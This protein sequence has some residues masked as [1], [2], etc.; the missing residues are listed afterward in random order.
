MDKAKRLLGLAIMVES[1]DIY[2]QL[3]D[4]GVELDHHE[5]DLYAKVTP[6]S[7]A[8]IKN[9]RMKDNVTVFTNKKDNKPWYDIPFAFTPFWDKKQRNSEPTILGN[10]PKTFT[11]DPGE[12]Y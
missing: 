2:Q 11:H 6:E 3:M 5:S 4:A 10:E 1:D 12:G 7:T 8:I 9:Y